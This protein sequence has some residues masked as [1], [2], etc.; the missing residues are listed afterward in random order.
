MNQSIYVS[1]YLPYECN[2]MKTIIYFYQRPNRSSVF[3]I[4]RTFTTS[5]IDF[6]FWLLN[7]IKI[8]PIWAA[9]LA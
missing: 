5:K 2:H 1:V 6:P 3:G 7:Q 8:T 4:P 9:P